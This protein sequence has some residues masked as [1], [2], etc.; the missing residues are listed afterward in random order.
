MRTPIAFAAAG[1]LAALPAL[2][3]AQQEPQQGLEQQQAQDQPPGMEEQQASL[4]VAEKEPFGKYITDAQGRALYMFTSDKK[5]AKE[6]T[7]YDQCAQA[8]PPLTVQAGQQPQLGAQIDQKLVGSF[9]RKDGKQQV[10]YNGWPLY[11]FTQDT[12]AGQVAGQDKK[13]FGGEWY[14][15]APSGERITEQ[16]AEAGGEAEERQ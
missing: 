3:Q 14:V 11:Y 16:R 2:A 4:Q 8:W 13:G 7:C 6:S 5:D 12:G 15:M 9:E 1:L 10:T